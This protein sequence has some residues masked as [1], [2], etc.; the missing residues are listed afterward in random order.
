MKYLHSKKE[1]YNYL[2]NYEAAYITDKILYEFHLGLDPSKIRSYRF[3][4]QILDFLGDVGGFQG[5]ITLIVLTI[6][7]FFSARFFLISIA[8]TFYKSDAPEPQ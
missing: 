8:A 4:T 2:D 3:S 7:E 1:L 5:A 6:G